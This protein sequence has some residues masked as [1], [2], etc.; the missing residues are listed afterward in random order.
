MGVE[1]LVMRPNKK[2]RLQWD[3]EERLRLYC[4]LACRTPETVD[5]CILHIIM[6]HHMRIPM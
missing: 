5:L 3:V 4:L 6:A 1:S 2:N